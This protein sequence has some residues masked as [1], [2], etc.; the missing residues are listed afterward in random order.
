MI[1]KNDPAYPEPIAV[2]ENGDA[3]TGAQVYAHSGLT[4]LE[5]FASAAMAALIVAGEMKEGK[6]MAEQAVT[7][8]L[9]LIKELEKN[10]EG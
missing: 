9:N 2:N 6:T 10:N 1:D 8:A 5:Y 3:F 7:E 4:K